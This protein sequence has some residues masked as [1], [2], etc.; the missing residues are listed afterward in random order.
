MFY[1]IAQL[2]LTVLHSPSR[3]EREWYS[4]GQYPH[5]PEHSAGNHLP[6]Q[7]T[8]AYQSSGHPNSCPNNHASGV[9][10]QSGRPDDPYPSPGYP[11]KNFV[12]HKSYPQSSSYSSPRKPPVNRPVSSGHMSSAPPGHTSQTNCPPHENGFREDV[13]VSS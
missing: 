8:S 5:K 3:D 2:C 7:N 13:R 4:G 9:Y 12:H 11:N 10:R 1:C 6:E